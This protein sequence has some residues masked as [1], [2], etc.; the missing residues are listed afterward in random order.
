[1]LPV[2][3]P[4]EEQLHKQVPLGAEGCHAQAHP[5]TSTKSASEGGQSLR[6]GPAKSQADPCK[7]PI[8]DWGGGSGR[9][10]PA[11]EIPTG[12]QLKSHNKR[13]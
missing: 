11:G 5:E 10:G 6:S 13:D 1:M 12:S 4:A 8:S 3:Q 2:L 9:Q 7:G